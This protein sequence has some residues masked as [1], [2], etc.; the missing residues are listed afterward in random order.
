MGT[1]KAIERVKGWARRCAAELYALSPR[2]LAPLQGKVVILTYHRVLSPADVRRQFVQAGMYVVDSVFESHVRFLTRHFKVVAFSELLRLWSTGEWDPASRYCVVTFDDGWIDTYQCAFPILRR[3][4]V[5]ATV[6]LPTSF[7]GTRKWFWPEIVGWLLATMLQRDRA[8]RQSVV[9]TLRQSFSWLA[10]AAECL[11][12]GNVDAVIEH[13]KGQDQDQI[14]NCVEKWMGLMRLNWPTDRLLMTWDEAREMQL[15]GIEFGSHSVSHRIMTKLSRES[16]LR[17][18]KD[19]LAAL[20]KE[21]LNPIPVFCYPNGDWLVEVAERV[22]AA[23]YKAATTTEFGYESRT[24]TTMFGLKRVSIHH[25]ITSTD[26]LF[27]FHLVGFNNRA[28]T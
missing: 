25:D 2:Y 14:D 21:R 13:F 18:A 9:K 12:R 1:I 23:G 20:R 10:P 16:M 24:P 5:P 4:G 19:S 26:S 22:Q 11:L 17:E 28:S 27:A 8:E 7:I 3:H 15:A 6:F